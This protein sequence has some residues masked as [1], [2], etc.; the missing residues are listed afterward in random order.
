MFFTLAVFALALAAV[1]CGG[2]AGGGPDASDE[3]GAADRREAR[4]KRARVQLVVRQHGDFLYSIN[5]EGDGIIITG[6]TGKGGVVGVPET[7]ENLPVLE[8]G[9]NAFRGRS[10][11]TDDPKPGDAITS[12]V[13]PDGVR[14]IGRG[15][16]SDCRN[17]ANVTLPDT[18]REIREVAFR[19][20]VNLRTAN[21]PA[22]LRFMGLN[23][24][25]RNGEL[26]RLI[27]P[28]G[29]TG[30]EWQGWNHFSGCA[31]LPPQARQR[32]QAMG[33]PAGF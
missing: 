7:I 33:Y 28:G 23:A 32:L 30:V 25:L 20:C 15:A 2:D 1:S 26:S 14:K 22:E 8:I 6:Y 16:F 10:A 17:L 13:I 31:K 21:L 19:D 5:A 27:I 9:D 3:T 24:F 12:V 18:V 11:E 4:E 29:I